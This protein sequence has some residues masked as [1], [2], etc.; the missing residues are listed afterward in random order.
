[1]KGHEAK[2]S[3]FSLVKI[4]QFFYFQQYYLKFEV[5]DIDNLNEIEVCIW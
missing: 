2:V 4:E 3:L 5:F 1:M